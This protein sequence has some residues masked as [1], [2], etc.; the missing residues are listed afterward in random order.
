MANA[1][2]EE[3]KHFGMD[4][5]FLERQK[6]KCR[7][8]FQDIILKEGDIVEHGEKAEEAEQDAS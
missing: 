1:K 8:A 4:L 7:V 6:P 5:A 3:L 2:G